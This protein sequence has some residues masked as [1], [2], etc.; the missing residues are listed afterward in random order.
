LW[1]LISKRI[2]SP[3]EICK[4]WKEHYPIPPDEPLDPRCF[5]TPN[6]VYQK[7]ACKNPTHYLRTQ[8]GEP[9]KAYTQSKLS[10]LSTTPDR[11]IID[12]DVGEELLIFPDVLTL[13]PL[14]HRLNYYFPLKKRTSSR[15][16][17][18]I[19][20]TWWK[21]CP[22]VVYLPGTDRPGS[23]HQ[24]VVG[25]IERANFAIAG[26]SGPKSV[27]LSVADP[28]Y[29]RSAWPLPR[30][31]PPKTSPR[32]NKPPHIKTA[33]PEC[34]GELSSKRHLELKRDEIV[35]T[36]CGLTNIADARFGLKT[37][38][39]QGDFFK[40]P[41]GAGVDFADDLMFE[42]SSNEA[43]DDAW[44]DEYSEV[45][46]DLGPT[47][48]Q[49]LYEAKAHK[50]EKWGREETKDNEIIGKKKEDKLKKFE[51]KSGVKKRRQ[52]QTNSKNASK[53]MRKEIW[54]LDQCYFELKQS[55]ELIIPQSDSCSLMHI[56]EAN[57]YTLRKLYKA[58][59]GKISRDKFYDTL[60]P[61]AA[62]FCEDLVKPYYSDYINLYLLP[63]PLAIREIAGRDFSTL[64]LT[65]S[66]S[67]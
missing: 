59:Y 25:P 58:K 42:P 20:G 11:I 35:C 65:Y 3:E 56:Y 55:G 14:Y 51:E 1:G 66:P 61:K 16:Y 8:R 23:Y 29:P 43:E 38:A 5:C 50:P 4:R 22:N 7:L 54:Q 6:Q 64:A 15:K 45:I 62:Q 9:V 30:K 57:K 46:S 24:D 49:G 28:L 17:G 32:Y 39:N 40:V 48:L 44:D 31:E 63:E 21:K 26:H 34:R 27:S 10:A 18:H 67:Q 33:C 12:L 52:S 53:S 19:I 13:W 60:L 47:K 36:Q 2:P 37:K 41:F